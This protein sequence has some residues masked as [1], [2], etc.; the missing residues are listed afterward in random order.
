L[1]SVAT[2]FAAAIGPLTYGLVTWVTGGNQRL[3]MLCT[4]LFF[5]VALIILKNISLAR[6]QKQRDM[7]FAHLGVCKQEVRASD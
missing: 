5:V 3:A 7:S 4:S 2:Q 6:A 1:W